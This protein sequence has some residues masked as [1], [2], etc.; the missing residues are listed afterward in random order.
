M[1]S[2]MLRQQAFSAR[3]TVGPVRSRAP[4][5]VVRAVQDVKGTVVSTAMQNTVVVRT[6]E[7]RS[8]GPGE[9]TKHG[10]GVNAW[11]IAA[12]VQEQDAPVKGSTSLACTA[13]ATHTGHN[14]GRGPRVSR[15][16]SLVSC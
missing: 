4:V 9:Q 14:L 5:V 15:L 3:P 12:G 10:F 16:L 6:L 1:Q 2:V 8:E 7:E 13:A 11:R